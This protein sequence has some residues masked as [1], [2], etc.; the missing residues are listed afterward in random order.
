MTSEE[1]SKKFHTDDV[2]LP[3]SRWRFW[4][5]VASCLHGTTNQS[6]IKIREVTRHQYGI[7][8]LDGQIPLRRETSGWRRNVGAVLLGYI[9]RVS[10][11]RRGWHHFSNTFWRLQKEKKIGIPKIIQ[12]INRFANFEDTLGNLN[13][14]VWWQNPPYFSH[15]HALRW[16][17]VKLTIYYRHYHLHNL[18]IK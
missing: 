16:V 5:V 12:K 13:I 17:P 18:A 4:L 3:R 7:F 1:Q 9:L 10:W 14:W 11:I 2:K 8:P 15:C 6:N